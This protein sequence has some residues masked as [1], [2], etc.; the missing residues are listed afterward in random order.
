MHFTL[1]NF[2][3]RPGSKHCW[4]VSLSSG[5]G[6]TGRSIP[7][8]LPQ[9]Y[10]LRFCAEKNCGHLRT[11][12]SCAGGLVTPEH[13]YLLCAAHTGTADRSV[14]AHLGCTAGTCWWPFCLHCTC[15]LHSRRERRK[16]CF[17]M[18]AA[19]RPSEP[20]RT[21]KT[22][23]HC[24]HRCPS[25]TGWPDIISI[26]QFQ[27]KTSCRQLN[28]LPYQRRKRVF[29]LSLNLMMMMTK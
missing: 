16:A 7:G 10:L 19:W 23:S 27:K 15:L 11:C 18:A 17:H 14:G 4:S 20:W 29:I 26:R 6:R 8:R 9:K 1:L 5:V 22:A 2:A 28:K 21:R 24:R 13:T 25:C 3:E 12:P